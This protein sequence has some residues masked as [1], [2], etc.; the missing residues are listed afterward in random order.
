MVIFFQCETAYLSKIFVFIQCAFVQEWNVLSNR[1]K[2]QVQ[3]QTIFCWNHKELKIGYFGL[4]Q[5]MAIPR[6]VGSFKWD[7]SVDSDTHYSNMYPKFWDIFAIS[8]TIFAAEEEKYQK[9][10]FK[11]EDIIRWCWDVL[12]LIYGPFKYR[13]SLENIQRVDRSSCIEGST[14]TYLLVARKRK[15]ISKRR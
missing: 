12:R 6:K 9:L 2:L 7:L 1:S 13:V 14:S 15:V 11:Y 10:P 8:C 5:K 3:D 4:L